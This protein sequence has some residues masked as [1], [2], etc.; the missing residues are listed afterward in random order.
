MFQYAAGRRLA[1]IL[2]AE[3]KLE[4]SGFEKYD[5]RYYML[6]VFN[7]QEEF[8]SSKELYL[9]KKQKKTWKSF[10]RQILGKD[11]KSDLKYVKEKYFHFDPAILKLN[12]GVYLDGYW[13]SE[14]YFTDI[15]A[16]ICKEFTLKKD[17]AGKN[18]ELTE[19]INSC[20]SVSLHIRRGDF[21]S[22]AEIYQT[23]GVCDLDYYY[24]CIEYIVEKTNTPIFFVFS[25]EPEW[26]RQ[27]LNLSHPVTFVTHNGAEKCYEDM[28]LMSQ[29]RHNIIANSSFSWWGAWLNQTPDKIVF[30][31]KKWFVT[32]DR[33][34][35]DLIPDKW[36][37]F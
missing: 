31:P 32:E 18:K 21:V 6:D 26:A 28:W 3:L 14:K 1:Y 20:E 12:D 37:T 19:I 16:I 15:A 4:L 33:D 25:D 11:K 8:L 24:K 34:T 17:P 27:N 2:D 36:I 5:K 35:R 9:N 10:L 23:H 30:A 29:C 13:Q 22:D 7:I